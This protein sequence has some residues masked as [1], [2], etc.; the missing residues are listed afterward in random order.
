MPLIEDHVKKSLARTG[1][2]YKEIHEWIDDPDK[3]VER[4]DI[5]RMLEFSRMFEEKYGEEGAQEYVQHLTDD[6][7]ARFNHVVEDM[8]EMVAKTLAYF[9]AAKS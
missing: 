9:G 2:G 1:K 4:H 7:N 6:L 5:G 3:K 8:K